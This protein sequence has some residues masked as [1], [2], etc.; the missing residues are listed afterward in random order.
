MNCKPIGIKDFT[1]AEGFILNLQRLIKQE[2]IPYQ[3]AVLRDEAEGAEK[4]HV[5]KNFENCAKALRGEDAGDGKMAG[6][7]R[8]LART[9]PRQRA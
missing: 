6:G 1:P 3:Y 4:S 9:V 5:V 7:S 2:V 8:I